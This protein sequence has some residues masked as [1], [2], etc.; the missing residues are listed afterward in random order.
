MIE[1]AINTL[2]FKTV[3]TWAHEKRVF[4]LW[5]SNEFL[6]LSDLKPYMGLIWALR[7]D[8]SKSLFFLQTIFSKPRENLQ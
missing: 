1:W 3:V 6:N 5:N 4:F 8:F 7:F 2:L